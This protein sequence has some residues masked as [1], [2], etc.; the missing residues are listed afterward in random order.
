M[1]KLLLVGLVLLS[2]GIFA[3]APKEIE[4]KVDTKTKELEVKISHGVPNVTKHYVN[5]LEVFINGEKKIIQ[6]SKTQ[7]NSDYQMVKYILPDIKKGD[8]LEVKADCNIY[9]SKK[10]NITIK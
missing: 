8:K 1:K 9:G 10:K 7:I 6:N 2:A 4:L 5:Q 3:H